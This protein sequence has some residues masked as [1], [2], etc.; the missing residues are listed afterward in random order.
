MLEK[1][2][3]ALRYLADVGIAK[4]ARDG[5]RAA[6][7]PSTQIRNAIESHERID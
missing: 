5:L 7:K 3:M 2:S 4:D 6:L 1:S